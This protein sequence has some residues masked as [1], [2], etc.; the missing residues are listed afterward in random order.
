MSARYQMQLDVAVHDKAALRKAAERRAVRDGQ[1]LAD[2][3]ETRAGN[4]D[5]VAADI[6]MLLDPGEGPPG[7]SVESGQCVYEGE[8]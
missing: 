6:H 7:L 8:Q 1:S 5:V 2:W 4:L 3:R